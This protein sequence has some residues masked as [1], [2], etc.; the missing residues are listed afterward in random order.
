MKNSDPDKFRTFGR[1]KGK[2]L[3]PAQQGRFETLYPKVKID[4]D[5]PLTAVNTDSPVWLT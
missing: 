1:A 5:T 4:T 2:K 3:S